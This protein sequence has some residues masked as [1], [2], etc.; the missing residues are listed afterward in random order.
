MEKVEGIVIRTQDY[1]ETHKIVTLF[2]KERGKVGLIARGAKKPK[3]QMAALTQPFVYG[4]F[5][6]QPSRNLG[7]LYQGDVTHSMRKMRED[8][9]KTAYAAY[10]AELT[11]K[12]LENQAPDPFLFDQLLHTFERIENDDSPEIIAMIY[13]LKI[14]EKGGF[15][16]EL[17][18]CVNCGRDEG[19]THFSI[20]EGGFLCS[21]CS[22]MDERAVMLNKS[23]FKIL[24]AIRFVNVERIGKVTIKEENR[25]KLRQL[26]DAYYDHF[27]GFYLRSRKFLQ[28]LDIFYDQS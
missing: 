28:Q 11:D 27:G 6:I 13:E 18:Y 23:L 2:T 1:S 4:V 22:Y 17:R 20:T 15:A 25:K 19:I 10:L 16:P 7:T 3:S 14:F 12:V 21:N 5:L 8:I 24:Q 9:I 26:L